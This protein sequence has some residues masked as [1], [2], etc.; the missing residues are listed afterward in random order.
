[1]SKNNLNYLNRTF[2]YGTESPIECYKLQVIA[3]YFILLLVLSLI[4]NSLLLAVFARYRCLRT[5]LNLLVMTLTA[6]NL[7]TSI[8][9]FSFVIPSNF[10][11]RFI[12]L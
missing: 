7:F 9:E 5:N 4:S 3:L 1:M 12:I 2:S 11:C 10:Q 8:V 6:L